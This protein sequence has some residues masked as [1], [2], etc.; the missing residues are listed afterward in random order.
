MVAW[1]VAEQLVRGGASRGA[2][3]ARARWPLDPDAIPA[4]GAG[5]L[6]AKA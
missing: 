4:L 3:Q 1:A 2:I 5:R 6:G